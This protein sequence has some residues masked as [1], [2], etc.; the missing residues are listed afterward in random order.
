MFAKIL[1]KQKIAFTAVIPCI[2]YIATFSSS[3]ERAAFEELLRNAADSIV[4][5]FSHPSELA[6]Y[7]AGRFVV[8]SCECLIAVWNGKPAGGLGGTADVVAFALQ[9]HRS[10]FHINPDSRTMS[11]IP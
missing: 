2:D 10:V 3:S 11:I 1:L 5:E 9:Q 7:A 8:E 6:F 4:L